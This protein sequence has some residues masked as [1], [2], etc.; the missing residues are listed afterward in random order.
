MWRVRS[1]KWILAVLCVAQLRRT[2]FSFHLRAYFHLQEGGFHSG[3]DKPHLDGEP[4]KRTR[5]LKIIALFFSHLFI[6]V[7]YCWRRRQPNKLRLICCA[8]SN[9]FV[10]NTHKRRHYAFV[11]H[12]IFIVIRSMYTH[13]HTAHELVPA[14]CHCQ[15]LRAFAI[16]AQRLN[17]FRYIMLSASNSRRLAYFDFVC[18][19]AAHSTP[20][21]SPLLLL[22]TMRCSLV[23][24]CVNVN[25]RCTTPYEAYLINNSFSVACGFS[26]G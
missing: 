18:K 11:F 20:P 16:C 13:K 2:Q 23:R 24:L 26:F 7:F 22:R 1:A 15:R 4:E 25:T 17:R 14:L 8:K 5:W 10:S 9:W 6:Y 3:F 12:S 19:I 21:P